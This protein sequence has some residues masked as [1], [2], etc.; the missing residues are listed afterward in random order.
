[1]AVKRTFPSI[2]HLY[3]NVKRWTEILSVLSKYGLAD[4]LSHS[5]IEFIK[6]RL[7]APD[8]A[9][10]ARLT[11]PER[12]RIAMAELGA[13]FIKF[14]QLLSTRPD[15]VGVELASE[16][17]KLQA[18]VPPDSFEQIKQS[19]EL[20]QGRPLEEVFLEFE[21][22]PLASTS[23]GQVHAAKLHD[24]TPVVVK[25]QRHGI[26]PQIETDLDILAGLAHLAERLDEFRPYQPRALVAEMTRTMPRELDFRRELRNL[27]QFGS[28]FSESDCVQI[29]EVFPQV[30]GKRVL[31]MGRLDGIK[32]SALS[33]QRN[34]QGEPQLIES[35]TDERGQ[36][37][38]EFLEEFARHGANL[39]LKMIFDE[40]FYHADPHPGNIMVMPSGDVGLLD[41]GMVGRISEQ[42][43]EDIEA[44]LVAIVNHDVLMLVTLI[45]RIGSCPLN[46]DETEL[47]REV[48]DF[49]GHYATQSLADFDMSGALREFVSIIRR[50]QITLPGEAAMLIKVLIELEGTSRLLDPGFSLMEIM[51][52]YRRKLILKRLSPTRQ[53][54]KLH[55]F[56]LQVEQLAES[57]PTTISNILEQVQR[58]KFDVHLD[59]R[60]LGPTVN[61]LVLGMMTSALFLG[62]SLMLSQKV[63]P[64]LF[65]VDAFLGFHKVSLLGLAGCL[66]S[67]TLGFRLFWAIRNSGNLD[68]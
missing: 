64:L 47:S 16:L 3:R 26:E 50:F 30:C 29:P 7:K 38:V 54:R 20:E 24:G 15:L 44:M 36:P 65:P 49:V 68:R 42:L 27:Q 63:P 66:A 57:M 35:L 37:K 56:Y 60:R 34:G 62:S 13:T 23:I 53:A 22:K 32:L 67:L 46:L 58:G 40:G 11:Q 8:G 39:Y 6:D 51:K 45:K 17:T 31:T 28:L 4:W 19:I 59:H 52:P 33:A 2:P 14:G 5:N 12:I 43:R 21:S 25:V 41:F 61:R 9:V 18:D 48:A 55:R 10:L 1:M